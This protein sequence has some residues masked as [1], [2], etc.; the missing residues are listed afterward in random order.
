MGGRINIIKATD[1][2]VFTGRLIEVPKVENGF[3]VSD[4]NRDILKLAVVNRYRDTNRQWVLST[5]SA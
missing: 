3:A 2:T 4:T 1:G 5:T